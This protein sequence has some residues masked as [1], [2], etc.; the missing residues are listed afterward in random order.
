M[1]GLGGEK[2]ESTVGLIEE[3]KGQVQ[4]RLGQMVCVFVEVLIGLRLEDVATHLRAGP[5]RNAGLAVAIEKP[6]ALGGAVCF[7]RLDRLARIEAFH[8]ER[9]KLQ[10][11]GL[12]VMG[13][14]FEIRLDTYARGVGASTQLGF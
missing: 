4:T 11:G 12:V 8:R 1:F 9:F 7:I 6:L 10:L 3:A 5:L 2:S 14:P 13:D